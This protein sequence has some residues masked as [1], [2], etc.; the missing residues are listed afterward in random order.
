VLFYRAQTSLGCIENMAIAAEVA[1]GKKALFVACVD[2]ISLGILTPPGEY[3]AD[4]AVGEGQGSESPMG[5]GGP[6]L[7]FLT[8]RKEHM[9]QMPGAGCR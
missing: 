9:R 3:G 5:F 7:G 8:C 4:I 1:H 6:H 2:P